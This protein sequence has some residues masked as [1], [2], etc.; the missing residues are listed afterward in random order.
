MP[1][2]SDSSKKN[3][4]FLTS[5]YPNRLHPTLGIFIKRHAEA[6]SR[7]ANV[8]VLFV[9]SDPN[10][11]GK[12]YD[13]EVTKDHNMPVVRVYYKRVKYY[14]PLLSG[15]LKFI[16]Y[17]NAHFKGLR[18]LKEIVPRIDIVHENVLY[19]AGI[20]ALLLKYFHGYPYLITEHSTIYLP[21]NG[22]Y[23]GVFTKWLFGKIARNARMITPVSEDLKKHMLRHGFKTKYRI[24]PNVVDEKIFCPAKR[25][26]PGTKKKILHISSLET[27]QKNVNGIIN[28]MHQLSAKRNDFELHIIGYGPEKAQ[29]I[30]EAGGLAGNTVFFLGK[31]SEKE[32]AAIMQSSDFF[33]LFSNYET[34]GCVLIEAM[35]CGLPIVSSRSGGISEY[36]TKEMGIIIEPKDE[37]GLLNAIEY[38]L[39]NYSKYDAQKIRKYALK[40]FT[41]EVVGKQFSDIYD[42]LLKDK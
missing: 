19:R 39:D 28:V 37:Q 16:S 3:I 6:V 18:A 35:A 11:K 14:I 17:V 31:K 10:L 4:L 38:M 32:I 24:V 41:Y 30:K 33:V 13:I 26:K 27:K 2:K 29:L 7:Y 21:A 40:H 12:T 34:F 25:D 8:A 1:S 20:F 5:W 9:C 36:I 15:F 22:T 23:K 42:Y